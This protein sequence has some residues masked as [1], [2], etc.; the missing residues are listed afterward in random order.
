MP[1][2]AP[3]RR[4]A[5]RKG[6]RMS[7]ALPMTLRVYQKLSAA[8]APLAP[9]L[10]QRRLQQG[11]EDPARIGERPRVAHRPR[12]PGPRGWGP[13]ARGPPALAAAAL[14]DALAPQ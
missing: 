4:S 7:S 12:P 14:C 2:A 8:A 13:A 1:P 6:P 9:A 10:I 3:M 5:V 11:K